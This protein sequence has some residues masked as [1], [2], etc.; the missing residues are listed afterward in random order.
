M[1]RSGHFIC[2]RSTPCE[3]RYRRYMAR[4]IKSTHGTDSIV[5]TF[6]AVSKNGSEPGMPFMDRVSVMPWSGQ[7]QGRNM[8]VIAVHR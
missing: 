7:G 3:R 2:M 6:Q 1:A 5:K 8:T 4:G